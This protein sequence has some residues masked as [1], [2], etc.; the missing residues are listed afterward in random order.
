ARQGAK[1][2]LADI[3]P[4][5]LANARNEI[6]QLSAPVVDVLTDVSKS[7]DVE[8]LAERTMSEFGAVHLLFNNAGVGG[9]SSVWQSTVADWGWVLGVNLWGVIHGV[10]T[11]LPIMFEQGTEGHIINTASVAG[12]ISP[13]MM[14]PY[15]VSKH[16]VVTL[17][18]TLFHELAAMNSKIK[19]SVLCPAWVNTGICDADRNRPPTLQNADRDLTPE[20]TAQ[21][22]M[23]RLATAASK[24]TPEMVAE[25]TLDA[26]RE[27]KFYILT[28]PNIKPAVL[29][30]VRAIVNENHPHDPMA[31]S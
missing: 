7:E 20:E 4:P 14:G 8:R 25:I 17:S 9:G 30:R 21:D 15:N 23:I 29:A 11:F 3:E 18:E 5:A 19:V 27:E 2:V 12:L 1:I 13:P 10:R 6:E 24:V 16:G 26:I 31:S 22:Q 28:H